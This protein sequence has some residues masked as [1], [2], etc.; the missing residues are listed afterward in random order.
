MHEFNIIHR[1]VKLDNFLVGTSIEHVK[2][3]DFG[4]STIYDPKYTMKEAKG[5]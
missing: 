4:Q 1:D 3:I 2:L 5:T